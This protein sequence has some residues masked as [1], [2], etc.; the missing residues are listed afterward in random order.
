MSNRQ[1]R[2]DVLAEIEACERILAFDDSRL[3]LELSRTGM[4]PEGLARRIEAALGAS[5]PA[6]GDGDGQD[7]ARAAAAGDPPSTAPTA[8]APGLPVPAAG[9]SAVP[10]QRPMPP[11]FETA[12]RMKFF[13]ATRGF[14]FFVTDDGQGDVLVHISCLRLAGHPTVYEGARVHA[15]VVRGAKGLQAVQI[16][17]IDQS[18]AVHPSQLP[19]RTRERVQAE[20]DWVRAIVKWYSRE[21]GYGFVFE[22][23]GGPDCFVHAD[24]LRRWGVAPLWPKQVVEIRWGV[25]TRGRMVAEI[26]YPGGLTPLPPLH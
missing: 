19:Q 26:R 5:P 14:G 3:D 23:E 12:G 20:S 8:A 6:A 13:D 2:I 17:N 21:G 10:A 15:L 11:M 25:G 1:N 7:A 24:V 9:A 18:L 4:D 16:L 22:R